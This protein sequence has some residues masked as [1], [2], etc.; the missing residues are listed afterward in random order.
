MN[1]K[2]NLNLEKTLYCLFLFCVLESQF[3]LFNDLSLQEGYPRPLSAL[4]KRGETEGKG[5]GEEEEVEQG[6]MWDPKEGPV[7]GEIGE[8]EAG[9]GE[10]EESNT[11]ADLIRGGVNGI[12]TE[13]DGECARK[14]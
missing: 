13:R 6:L 7:W 12:T 14:K 9:G 2:P 3:W 5:G 10:E 4:R 8:G 1:C 11:W